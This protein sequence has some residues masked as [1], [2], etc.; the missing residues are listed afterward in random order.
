M[1]R[2]VTSPIS[3]G[4]LHGVGVG[5]GVPAHTSSDASRGDLGQPCTVAGCRNARKKSVPGEGNDP[6]CAFT[7]EAVLLSAGS[8][9]AAHPLPSHQRQ[10]EP[11]AESQ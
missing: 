7:V 8:V 4:V 6:I 9:V 2:S 10:V 1:C 5:V 11:S 3:S